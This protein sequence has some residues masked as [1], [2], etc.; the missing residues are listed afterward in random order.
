MA[1]NLPL[2]ASAQPPPDLPADP[3]LS[4]ALANYL[5][6]FSLWCRRGF[7]SK[8]DTQTAAP[9]LLLQAS[10]AA[11]G[12]NPKVFLLSVNSAGTLAVVNVPLGGGKP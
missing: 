6:Q 5:R 1:L 4:D 12:T 9:G 2:P 7:Q 10:D 11:P 8:V 3:K